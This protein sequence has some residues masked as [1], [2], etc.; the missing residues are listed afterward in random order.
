MATSGTYYL[1]G[2]TLATATA[3]YTDAATTTPAAD[4]WYSDGTISRE[5]T[6]GLLGIVQTCPTCP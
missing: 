6:S 5:Q 1:D 3:V 4:G 2:P